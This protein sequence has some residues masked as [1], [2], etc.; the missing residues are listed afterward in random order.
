MPSVYVEA[1]PIKVKNLGFFGFDHLQLVYVPDS[2]TSIPVPQEEWY[3]IEGTVVT[4]TTGDVLGVLGDSGSLALWLANGGVRGTALEAEIGTPDVRGGRLLTATNADVDWNRMAAHATEIHDTQFVY[5]SFRPAFYPIATLNST[6]FIASVLFSSG[7]DLTQNFP[8]RVGR[9]PGYTTL[10]GTIGDDNMS[11]QLKFN[12]LFGGWG[13]DQFTGGSAQGVI[14]RM[15]G[16]GD[17]DVISWSPGVD[18]AH[19]GDNSMTYDEDGRD[20]LDFVGA[21]QVLIEREA[22]ATPHLV[23]DFK[24][25]HDQGTTWLFSIDRVRWGNEND[26]ILLGE[27]V[28]LLDVQI[29]ID[30]GD[31]DPDGNGDELSFEQATGGLIINAGNDTGHFVQPTSPSGNGG[32]WLESVE[33][34]TGSS[35]ADRIYA[36]AELR[37]IEGGAGDDHIDARLVTAH[38][39]QSPL[40]YDIEINGGDGDDTII[41]SA[42]RSHAIGGEGS[43][44]F[45]LSSLTTG[46]QA[47]EFVIADADSQDSLYVPYAFLD[48][49]NGSFDGSQLMPILGAIGTF[50]ELQDEGWTLFYEHRT[51]SQIRD[52]NDQT[53]GVIDFV[54]YISFVL[55]GS[56]LVITVERGEAV[57]EDII[58]EDDGTTTSYVFISGLSETDAVIRVLDFQEGDLGLNFIDPGEQDSEGYYPNWDSAVDQLNETMLPAFDLRPL[59]PSSDP[60]APGNAPPRQVPVNGG[61]GDDLISLDQPADVDA[62]AGNDT[63]VATGNGSDSIDGGAGDDLMAGGGGNDEYAV[64]SAGDTVF[65]EIGAG[66]DTVVASIDY[67]LP[68]FVEHLTLGGSAVTATGNGLA[69]RL[70]GNGGDN[71]LIGLDGGDTLV[72]LGGDDTLIGGEGSDG[73]IYFQGDGHDVIVDTGTGSGDI[74]ELLLF[75]QL[76]PA[77]ITATRMASALDD[78]ILSFTG[79][80]RVTIAGFYTA[81]DAGIDEIRFDDGTVMTRAEVDTLAAG[82]AIV[83]NTAPDVASDFE[84]YYGGVDFIVPAELLLAND[85]DDE[86]DP[87]G[88]VAVSGFSSGSGSIDAN[89]DVQL[90]LTPGFDG[91]LTF[92]YTVSD[93]N[94]GT[95]TAAVSMT[96]VPNSAPT[97]TAAIADQQATVGQTFA[98]TVPVTHYDDA[99]NDLLSVTATLADGSPLPAWLNFDWLTDTLHG[100]P[101]GGT[102][103][104]L[105]ILLTASDGFLPVTETFTLTIAPAAGSVIDGNAD[106]NTIIGGGDHDLLRGHGGNDAFSGNAGADY[107]DGGAGVDRVSYYGQ[108]ADLVIRL[109][110][111]SSHGGTAEGDLLIGMENVTGGFGNDTIMGNADDNLLD[112]QDGNDTLYGFGGS[113]HL[114]GGGGDD[115][116]YGGAGHDVLQGGD[117]DDHLVGGDGNDLFNGGAGADQFNGGA[118]VDRASYYDQTVSLTIHLDGTT[119]HGGH[120]EGDVLVAIE[121]LTAGAGNDTIYDSA[122]DN[123]IDA[124]GGDDTIHSSLGNDL[125]R[126]GAGAD[127]FVFAAGFGRDTILDMDFAAGGDSIDLSSAAFADFADLLAHASENGTD[128]IITIDATNSLTLLNVAV[129]Q[130]AADHFLLA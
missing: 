7:Y 107:M 85:R 20:T 60:N 70:I 106:N 40:G 105:T 127:T 111:A 122:D 124:Y 3:V 126:G 121:W 37:G 22:R 52:G 77:D 18:F 68:D 19:G 125:L 103:G 49:S 34:L 102:A 64:D 116:L 86:G 46:P 69:N 101:P 6:S 42:G 74:D 24:A 79:G 87:L 96:I 100:T 75:D 129:A 97:V 81:A 80:G 128:T 26:S 53:E 45:V 113:D 44:R 84:L 17:D 104:S 12:A 91:D 55:D 28:E 9:S 120:A 36:G 33:W 92:N 41:G 13:N 4:G 10:L 21:G 59:A 23:P 62:G 115:T 50:D 15:Y 43:D 65:E 51:Q 66:S 98:L 72:G 54:A 108:T 39:G 130:L 14:D 95:A 119:S 38:S 118:G 117:G 123:F 16:G 58:S 82:A 35:Y 67:T 112:A 11:I 30:L 94:G 99:D 47:V 48:G 83:S 25:S 1:L 93:G 78:L 63:I 8:Y 73:Y 32:I 88:I 110:N 76:R 114:R 29:S 5:T 61:N 90:S 56:D 71:I 2:L 57:Q 31:E 109:D 27:G 89:G